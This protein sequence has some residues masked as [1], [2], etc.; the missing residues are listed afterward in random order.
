VA[1]QETD[2]GPTMMLMQAYVVHDM[3]HENMLAA[4]HC[5]SMLAAKW[6]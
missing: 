1:Q 6:Y 3:Q 2:C 5:L 4:A